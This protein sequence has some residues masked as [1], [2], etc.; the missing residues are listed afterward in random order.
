MT[1]NIKEGMI[2][3]NHIIGMI[4]KILGCPIIKQG[5]LLL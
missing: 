3:V 2:R 5:M 1:K 4:E